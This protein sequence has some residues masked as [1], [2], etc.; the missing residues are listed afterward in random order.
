MRSA[1]LGQASRVL[2]PAWD[3]EIYFR[4]SLPDML[5]GFAEEQTFRVLFLKIRYMEGTFTLRDL[6]RLAFCVSWKKDFAGSCEIYFMGLWRKTSRVT[7]KYI[8]RIT[9]R[10]FTKL[11]EKGT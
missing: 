8:T 1:G 7:S 5:S 9:I 6:V 11:N 4:V 10:N 3:L 2:E